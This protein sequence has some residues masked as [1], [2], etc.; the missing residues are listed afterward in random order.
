MFKITLIACGN[1]MP[2]WVESA[3]IEFSKRLKEFVNLSMIEIP[4]VK[5]VK[6]S[7]AI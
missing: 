5:R 4:L 1:K 2:S 3:V 7:D 6:S